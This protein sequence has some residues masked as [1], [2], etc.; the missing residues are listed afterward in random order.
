MQPGLDA[1]QRRCVNRDS[2]LH[3]ES[4]DDSMRAAGASS[5]FA[6]S[7]EHVRS[8]SIR[9]SPECRPRKPRQGPCNASGVVGNLL[10]R[11]E[12]VTAPCCVLYPPSSGSARSHS[13][14]TIRHNGGERFVSRMLIVRANNA[15][16]WLSCCNIAFRQS[17]LVFLTPAAP[18]A[19]ATPPV[20]RR[21]FRHA[22]AIART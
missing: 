20:I 8:D 13:A 18:A 3:S 16:R 21:H 6:N 2:P 17:V 19:I 5:R 7:C 10:L 9:Q 12:V 22:S 15:A 1:Q 11:D 4:S 14:T